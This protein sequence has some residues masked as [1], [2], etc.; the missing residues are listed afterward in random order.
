MSLTTMPRE[1]IPAAS[2]KTLAGWADPVLITRRGNDPAQRVATWLVVGLV[3]LVEAGVLAPLMKI[4]LNMDTLEAS[5]VS[6][7]VAI[8][9]AVVMHVAG[10]I[11]AGVGPHRAGDSMLRVVA[12]VSAW[13]MLGLAIT[14]LRVIGMATSTDLSAISA[15]DPGIKTTDIVAAA[16]FLLL[17]TIAGLLAFATDSRND[18]HEAMLLTA[19]RRESTLTQLIHWE[20]VLVRLSREGQRR[21]ADIKHLDMLAK[22]EEQFSADLRDAA[23]GL[24]RT[25]I[26]RL[27]TTPAVMGIASP[28]HPEHPE[29]KSAA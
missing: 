29:Q 4:V 17:Y 11:R 22:Y 16:M 27:K 9:S 18:V 2:G 6:S 23:Q 7:A 10:R 19:G 1:P 21:A 15:P 13:T 26:G 20:G 14:I 28:K 25:E 5:L 12:L 24:V 8:I 3:V